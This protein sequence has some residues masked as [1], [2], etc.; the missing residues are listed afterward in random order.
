MERPVGGTGPS[1]QGTSRYMKIDPS[2]QLCY[3]MIGL[4]SAST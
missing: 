2:M 4:A 1:L 3:A